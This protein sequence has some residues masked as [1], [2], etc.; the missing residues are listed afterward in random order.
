M[1]ATS[2]GKVARWVTGYLDRVVNSKDVAAVDDLVSPDYVGSGHGW[3]PDRV[4][5]RE[6]YA[7]QAQSRPDWRITVQESIEVGDWVAVRAHASGTVSR[8]R[9]TRTNN[10]T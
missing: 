9:S 1:T 3:A 10:C 8:F 7:W 2:A 5:L 6:F 4:T